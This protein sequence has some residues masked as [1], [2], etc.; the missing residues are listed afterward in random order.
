EFARYCPLGNTTSLAIST[1][2]SARIVLQSRP[3]S[4]LAQVSNFSEAL[5]INV[6]QG[7]EGLDHSTNLS[8]NHELRLQRIAGVRLP[9]GDVQTAE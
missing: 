5:S 8:Q 2:A 7:I 1:S 3:S 4:C 6:N 9:D